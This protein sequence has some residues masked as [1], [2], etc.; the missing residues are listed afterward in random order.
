MVFNATFVH[1]EVDSRLKL[2][3]FDERDYFNFP[4]VNSPFIYNNIP[5]DPAVL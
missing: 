1:L 3:P 4:I 2:K 5:A